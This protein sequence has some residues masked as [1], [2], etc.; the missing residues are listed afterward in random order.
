MLEG[1]VTVLQL[2]RSIPG[3]VR[4]TRGARGVGGQAGGQCCGGFLSFLSPLGK[5]VMI[6]PI[7]KEARG[8]ATSSPLDILLVSAPGV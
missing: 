1:G 7:W 3:G 2:T 4:I 5:P 8:V 6:E